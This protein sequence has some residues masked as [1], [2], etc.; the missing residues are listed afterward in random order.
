MQEGVDDEKLSDDVEDVKQ[1]G[2]EKRQRQIEERLFLPTL[3]AEDEV[4]LEVGVDDVTR[5]R[6]NHVATVLLSVDAN[7]AQFVGTLKGVL[8]SHCSFGDHASIE[9]TTIVRIKPSNSNSW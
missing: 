1:F 8:E 3:L 2:D 7:F 4:P 5:V 6:A 9:A